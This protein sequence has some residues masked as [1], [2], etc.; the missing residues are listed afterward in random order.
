[1]M[2]SKVH[3]LYVINLRVQCNFAAKCCD[4]QRGHWFILRIDVKR[5][6]RT[7]CQIMIRSIDVL[8][9]FYP[10]CSS[11]HISCLECD[12]HLSGGQIHT[13]LPGNLSQCHLILQSLGQRSSQTCVHLGQGSLV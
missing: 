11:T 9:L 10:L 1:M 6:M 12:W 8:S 2:V 4:L 7:V 13:H 3:M 5:R